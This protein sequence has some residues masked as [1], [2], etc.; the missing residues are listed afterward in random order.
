MAGLL[1]VLFSA[2]HLSTDGVVLGLKPLRFTR[3][4]VHDT[5]DL[6]LND[7]VDAPEDMIIIRQLSTD[8]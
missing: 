1:Y 7:L 8:D 4:L 2:A 5:H 3:D 6:I